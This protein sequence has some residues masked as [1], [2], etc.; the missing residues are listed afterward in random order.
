MRFALV[1]HATHEAGVKMG[2]IGAVLDGLLSTPTYNANVERTVLVGAMDLSDRAAVDRM[3]APGNRLTI[4]YSSH[5]GV[6]EVDAD[7][8][9]RLQTIERRYNVRLLYGRRAFGPYTHEVILV[10]AGSAS[11]GP[12]NDYKSRL[13]RYFGIQSDRYDTN[14]EYNLHVNAAEPGYQALAEVVGE[15]SGEQII[16]AHEFMGMPLA[17]SALLHAPKAHRI[18]FYGHEVATARPIV[19]AHPGHDT[20]FY[21]VLS[22]ALAEGLYLEDVFGD[23]T[24]FFKHGLLRP[25]AANCDNVFAVGDSVVREMRFLGPAWQRSNVDLVYNGVPARDV[26]LE[27]KKASHARLQRYCYNLLGYE[28]DYVF[29]HVTRFVPSKGLWRDIRVMEHLD[30]L[31]ARQGKRAVLFTLATVIPGGRPAE[32]VWAM[33]AEYGWPVIHRETPIV[34]DGQQVPDLVSHEIPY[35]RAIGELNGRAKALQVVLVNQ[36]GWSQE[37][38]GRRMPAD[39]TFADIRL[40]SDLEFGQSIYEPFGIA[41]VEPLSAGAL[42]VISSVC[43]CLGFIRRVAANDDTPNVIVAD[44]TAAGEAI[45][46]VQAA[47]AIDRAHR[48]RIEDAQARIV[49]AEIAARLPQSD[50]AARQLLAAGRSLSKKMSWEVVAREWLLPG[51]T[52]AIGARST[53]GGEL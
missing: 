35:Y 30:P 3:H 24:G 10:D 42:C 15:V 50:A 11:P 38:C 7:L 27:E 51:L 31:L 29:T 14:A 36:F 26:T 6:Y 12:I 13:Y 19:E 37:R 45:D 48:D 4:Q 1:V 8:S 40:G 34:V 46:S 21:N 49:A 47:L 53:H 17:Y 9:C 41:Q 33:E 2:G 44:Y 39:M 32:A 18:I 43:G 16:I 52:R 28:P 25:A 23:R 20:M 5:H 22:R